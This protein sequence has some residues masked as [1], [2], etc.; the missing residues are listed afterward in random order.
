M[1]MLDWSFVTLLSSALLFFLFALFSVVLSI[2]TRRKLRPLKRRPP[3]NKRKRKQFMMKRRKFEKQV[4]RQQNTGIFLIVLM[5]LSTGGAVYTRNYQMN[6]LNANDSE[7]IVQSYY[8][9]DEVELQLNNIKNDKNPQK[10]IKNLRELSLSLSSYGAR[11]AYQGLTEEGQMLLNRHFVLLKELGTNLS[12]QT[13]DTLGNKDTMAGYQ[14]DVNKVKDSQKKVFKRF[15]VNE[16]ALK[17]K[18]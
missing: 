18:K 5:L 2:M 4:K 14:K 13:V 17:T 11:R 16:A 7:S 9:L 12:S 3:K 15:K 6:N 8:L 1:S 10:S